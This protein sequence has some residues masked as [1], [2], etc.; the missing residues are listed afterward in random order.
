MLVKYYYAKLG[1]PISGLFL[2]HQNVLLI[3]FCFP[4]SS[5]YYWPFFKFRKF[6]SV[7]T[8]RRKKFSLLFLC[9]VNYI[10]LQSS[11]HY[12]PWQASNIRILCHSL[13]LGSIHCRGHKDLIRN[14][15]V[16]VN[17]LW[18]F[19]WQFYQ[20]FERVNVNLSARRRLHFIS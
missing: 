15:F 6:L 2:Y 10:L 7:F 18:G 14:I 16:G 4:A 19:I 17:Q 11:K 8:V 1:Q 3:I 20:Y 9:G 5:I 12:N 13:Q